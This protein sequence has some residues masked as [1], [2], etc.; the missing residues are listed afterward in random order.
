MPDMHIDM[1]SHSGFHDDFPCLNLPRNGGFP[2]VRPL[3]ITLSVSILLS[4]L[5][6]QSYFSP[7]SLSLA[8]SLSLSERE[9]LRLPLT[10]FIL[11]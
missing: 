9:E 7:L 2:Q 1:F 10:P 4:I 3:Y 11:P 8:A 6:E 5:F